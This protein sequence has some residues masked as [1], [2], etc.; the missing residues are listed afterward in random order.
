MENHHTVLVRGDTKSVLEEGRKGEGEVRRGRK[1]AGS[2]LMLAMETRGI[3]WRLTLKVLGCNLNMYLSVI[4][5]PLFS[6]FPCLF[7]YKNKR[8]QPG[9]T[10]NYVTHTL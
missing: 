5:T 2:N 8:K 4:S 9:G 6:V 1:K 3:A 10:N 7:N